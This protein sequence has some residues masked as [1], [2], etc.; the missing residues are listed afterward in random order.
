MASI[1]AALP[2]GIGS[3]ARFLLPLLLYALVH[4]FIV[5]SP[6]AV[7]EWV[8]FLA[9]LMLDVLTSGPLGF[10]ALTLLGGYVIAVMQEEWPGGLLRRWGQF[11]VALCG[12]TAFAWC[13][14][15][16]YFFETADV[17]PL[18]SAAVGAGLA[19]PLVAGIAH[20]LVPAGET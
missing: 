20:L 10:W 18:A 8:V 9:G 2:W 19:Y 5:R 7:A 15:T 17:R 4:A 16:L 1:V 14:A 6:G 13:L 11:L 3:Q 12:V